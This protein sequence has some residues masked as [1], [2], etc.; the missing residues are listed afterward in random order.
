M[1]GN[2]ITIQSTPTGQ[3]TITVPRAIAGSKGWKK[4]TVLEFLE[5]RFGD[6]LLKEVKE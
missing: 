6:V 3:L 2:K 4:G 1:A 5:D